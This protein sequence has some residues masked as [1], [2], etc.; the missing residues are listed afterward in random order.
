MANGHFISAEKC[1]HL[2]T[3]AEL[4]GSLERFASATGMQE[5]NMAVVRTLREIA[6]SSA[7]EPL[8]PLIRSP[9]ATEIIHGVRAEAVDAAAEEPPAVD[10]AS[11]FWCIDIPVAGP[12][13]A[14]TGVLRRNI[15]SASRQRPPPA[16]ERDATDAFV[17]DINNLLTV[18]DGGLR[19]L[20][21]K[22][23]AGDRSRIVANLHRAV[24]R[25]TS[26]SRNRLDASRV[27][28]EPSRARV[29]VR[30]II[31]VR[32]LLDQALRS[33]VIVDAEIDP[34]LHQFLAD[35]EELHLTL[36]N[37]CKNAS[38]AMPGGGRISITARNVCARRD[39]RYI[40]IA[41]GDEGTGMPQDVLTRAF[42]PYFTTKEPGKGTGLG[43]D[44]VRRFVERSQGVV[45]IDSVPN[46]GT[47]VRML[48]PSAR[49]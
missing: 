32:N 44:Q 12:D 26:L 4:P 6:Q 23:D 27:D 45:R 21:L 7:N 40:E 48:F 19:L 31:D 9:A 13:G 33:D 5:A 2:K 37:L 22:T 3:M 8:G 49:T 18:I 46:A 28:R 38:D 39:G 17:H 25:G 43:L 1:S 11:A 16:P 29:C 14:I 24:E 15:G 10:E 36:L 41:V 47:I 35:P 42:E 20:D 34:E 30:H